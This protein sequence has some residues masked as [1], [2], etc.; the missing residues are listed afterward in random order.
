M[1]CLHENCNGSLI[2]GG[3]NDAEDYGM[4]PDEWELISN[5]TCSEC[6]LYVEAYSPVNR[7]EETEKED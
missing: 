7:D 1:K 4:D 6:K 2:C 5:Y 3:C